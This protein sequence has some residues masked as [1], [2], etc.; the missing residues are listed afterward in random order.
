MHSCNFD[1]K[2]FGRFRFW[3]TLSIVEKEELIALALTFFPEVMG[4]SQTKYQRFAEWLATQKGIL[5]TNVR[6][7]FGAGGKQ[8]VSCEGL[9]IR[10]APKV[11]A[12]LF[13]SRSKLREILAAV[14]AREL[15]RYYQVK[16]Q[17]IEGIGCA[18]AWIGN[19]SLALE[20]T[21]AGHPDAGKIRALVRKIA[22][23]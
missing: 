17:Q 6:D 2:E 16:I 14:S 3:N 4:A 22:G 19:A 10:D 1:D 8:T 23:V 18:A 12:T 7:V 11:L 20:E 5:C 15:A 13:N 21:L 9:V